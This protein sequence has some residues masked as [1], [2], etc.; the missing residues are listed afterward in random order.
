MTCFLWLYFSL[1]SLLLCYAWLSDT[2]ITILY[3]SIII[4]PFQ[5]LFV[6]YFQVFF[7]CV[8]IHERIMHIYVNMNCEHV[9]KEGT[10]MWHFCKRERWCYL[11]STMFSEICP[12]NTFFKFIF[13]FA[14]KYFVISKLYNFLGLFTKIS[15]L[16]TS[17]IKNNF[18]LRLQFFP[19]AWHSLAS[20]FEYNFYN[21]IN[22]LRQCQPLS[23]KKEFD[24]RISLFLRIKY[25]SLL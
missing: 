18:Y 2:W 16:I 14:L 11:Q 4:K 23:R 15:D 19:Y 8:T 17:H 3:S 6:R 20:T 13:F 5:L 9:Q 21:R 25:A 22:W 1:H 24:S 10:E 7:Y 12:N